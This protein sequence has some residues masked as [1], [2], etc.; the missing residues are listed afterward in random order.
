MGVEKIS[1]ALTPEE[2]RLISELRAVPTSNLK[3]RVLGLFAAVLDFSREPR[4]AEAQADGVPCESP[5]VSC[6]QCLHVEGMLEALRER[7]V[8][9]KAPAGTPV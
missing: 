4:C 1:V 6:E 5:G 2:W 3:G 7:T 8:S 9:A